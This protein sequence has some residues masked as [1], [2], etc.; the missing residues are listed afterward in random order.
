MNALQKIAAEISGDNA[1]EL[2]RRITAFSRSPGSSGYHAATDLIRDALVEHGLKVEETHYPLD[3]ETVVLDRTMPLAW[4]PLAAR[5][6]IIA[7]RQEQIVDFANAGS[8]VAWWSTSTR[9]GGVEAEVVD[10]GAGEREEDYAGKDL[11]GKVAFVSNADWHVTWSHVSETIARKGAIGIVTDFFLYP[12]PPIRT[13]ERIPEAIQLLRLEFNA[14]H[15]LEFWACSVD[16]PTGEKLRQWLRAGPVRIRADIQCKTFVGHGT[17]ILATIEGAELPQESVFILAHSSTGSRP[18][19]NCASGAAL[20]AEI[21]KALNRLIE[22]G[23]V[24][25][26]RR[27]L[28]FLLVSEGLGS[29]NYI[30]AHE[31]EMGRVKA[32]YCLESVGH[33]QRKL[34]GTLYFCRAPD[35]TPSFVNDHFDAV[36]ER[37]PKHWG[38]VGRNERDIS[39]I[40]VSQV[41]YTPWSDNS[42]WAAHGVPSTLLM[43]WPD[44]YFHSQLL[45]VEVTEPSVFAY[46]G[47]LVAGSTY[48]IAAAGLEEARWLARW[49]YAKSAARLYRERQSLLWAPEPGGAH[50]WMRKRLAFLRRRDCDALASLRGLVSAEGGQPFRAEIL[51]LQQRLIAVENDIL[52]GGP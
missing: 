1:Y 7:P 43:S 39:P 45:T 49:M 52:T 34:N 10:V 18:G 40:V 8:S 36:L 44:E 5:V 9:S 33:S 30:Q 19:A 26:P 3:G 16:Y 20:L 15:A 24:R 14:T 42:T 37:M 50:A 25:R 12:T 21:A 27:S 11:S 31:E 35:S 28:K 6:D 13:R 47:A 17:N 22:A 2:T 23:E 51:A 38:W 48:E 46:S 32:S 41:P 29:Y 4:E